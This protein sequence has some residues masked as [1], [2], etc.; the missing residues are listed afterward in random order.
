MQKHCTVPV[1][2]HIIN[3]NSL[4]SIKGSAAVKVLRSRGVTGQ[5][6]S[7][8]A[9]EWTEFAEA[10]KPGIRQVGKRIY[11]RSVAAMQSV[12]SNPTGVTKYE[13]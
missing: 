3:T 11:S 1:H 8:Y 9:F 7:D 13:P 4:L 2:L 10:P 12:G 6:R 5:R